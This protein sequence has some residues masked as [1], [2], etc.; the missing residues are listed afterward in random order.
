M[1]I[2]V[3]PMQHVIEIAAISVKTKNTCFYLF[4]CLLNLRTY[5]L[6]PPQPRRQKTT[7][8]HHRAFT[9]KRKKKEKENTHA[10]KNPISDEDSFI[11]KRLSWCC[12]GQATDTITV[13]GVADYV[14]NVYG[15]WR[16]Q[17]GPMRGKMTLWLGEAYRRDNRLPGRG[18]CTVQRKC[19]AQSRR[20]HS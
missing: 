6:S 14:G 17:D 3:L 18:L 19:M 12:T 9:R 15:C 7:R 8:S 10:K 5:I 4:A 1:I 11:W 2:Y 20:G 13:M 16:L